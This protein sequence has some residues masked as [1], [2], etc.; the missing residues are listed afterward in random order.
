MRVKGAR[1]GIHHRLEDVFGRDLVST[2]Q[3]PLV[4][5]A[6]Q[7][8]AIGP[9]FAGQYQRQAVGLDALAPKLIE[10]L[11][12]GWPGGLGAIELKALLHRPVGFVGQ[13]VQGI[14][15]ALAVALLVARENQKGRFDFAGVDDVVEALAIG[16]QF[17]N[18]G[19]GEVTAL[20]IERIE[21]T[22]EHL[23]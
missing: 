8:C 18:I 5:L 20:A 12:V 16:C 4:T 11:C 19:G 3:H 2:L 23:L 21:K 7:L 15:D 6:Q 9:A 17:R 14:L 1:I 10:L 13:Q 22:V